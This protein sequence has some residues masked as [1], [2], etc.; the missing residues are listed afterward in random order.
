VSFYIISSIA[1]SAIVGVLSLLGVIFIAHRRREFLSVTYPRWVAIAAAL[2]LISPLLRA[3]N[4]FG[5]SITDA[6]LLRRADDAPGWSYVLIAYSALAGLVL[7]GVVAA[8][9][10]H[11]RRVPPNNRWRGP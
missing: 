7:G 10:T 2:S 6:Y 3:A 5:L 11:L 9:A 4:P 8:V 1:L